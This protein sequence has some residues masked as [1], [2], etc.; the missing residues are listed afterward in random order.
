MIDYSQNVMEDKNT[1]KDT[2]NN[3]INTLETENKRL[4]RSVEELRILNDLA[5]AIGGL[6]N[7]AE[8]LATIIQR[9][10]ISVNAEQGNITLIDQNTENRKKTLVRTTDTSGQSEQFH[11]DQEIMI[12]MFRNKRAL[13][14][15]APRTDPRFQEIEWDASVKSILCVPLMVKGSMIG[16][17]TVYNK[18][19]SSGFTSDDQRL[20][21]I[22]ASQ[23]AQVVENARLTEREHTMAIE[24]TKHERKAQ[25]DFA[26]RLI[27][28]QEQER[29]RIAAELHDSIGQNLL[30]IKNRAVLGSESCPSESPAQKELETISILSSEA[31]DEVRAISYNLHPYQLDRLGLT[32]AIQSIINRI[33]GSTKAQIQIDIAPIDNH[34]KKDAEI[35]IYRVV[36]EGM[37]N[38]VKHADASMIRL[39]IHKEPDKIRISI[40]DDGKGFDVNTLAI[41]VPMSGG[42]GLKGL[43]ERVRILA[44]TFSIE[45][46]PNKGTKLFISLPFDGVHNG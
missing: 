11:L 36:Q 16:V 35:H 7:T 2:D 40:E 38:A 26:R 4:R 34:F 23:S 28:S 43:S 22:V 3:Y 18:Q 14:L 1:K 27:D 41:A 33:E 37:S 9:S 30:I 6:G 44:G 19:E 20:L 21:A 31:I 45:S 24:H 17:L 46:S 5:A 13:L 29:K 8:I 10:I 42:F 25:Q 12:W 32:K 39:T 15:N